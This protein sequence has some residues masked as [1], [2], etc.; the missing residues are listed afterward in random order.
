MLWLK[1]LHLFFVIAWF[2]GI[3]YLPRL[4]VY[5]AESE[6]I[7]VKKQLAV[8]A[9]RLYWFV[10]PFALLTLIF[11]V[12]L[13][14]VYGMDWFAASHWLHIKLALVV[15]LYLYHF[16]LYK[17]LQ[18]VKHGTSN[19]SVKFF[20]IINELPVLVLFAIIALAVVKFI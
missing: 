16:Y 1:A 2:A 9:H 20:R 11:G 14:A 19:H 17:L 10:T 4:F 3:F 12:A 13:I 6:N 7:A 18:Q 8:M 15:P 5:H